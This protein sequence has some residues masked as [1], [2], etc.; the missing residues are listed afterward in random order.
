[1]VFKKELNEEGDYK[2]VQNVRWDILSCE[3]TESMEWYDT[4]E[5][6]EYGNPI[7]DKRIVINKGWDEFDS[8]E[9]AAE[10]YGLT[11]DPLPP[12]NK[13]V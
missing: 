6:D 2:D 12:E 4:G 11:Y 13:E 9:Q 5:V 1:M 10:A 8:I 7:M 3:R